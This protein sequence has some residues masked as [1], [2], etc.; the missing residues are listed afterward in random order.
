MVITDNNGPSALLILCHG[1]NLHEFN[2]LL[3]EKM[4]AKSQ[5]FH[6]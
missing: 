6:Y 2:K 3:F 5:N 1:N 4:H